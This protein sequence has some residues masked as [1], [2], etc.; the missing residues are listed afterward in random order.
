MTRASRLVLVAPLLLA[1]LFVAPRASAGT[2][3][4]LSSLAALPS[5]VAL[6][7]PE[8]PQAVPG[9]TVKTREPNHSST[10]WYEVNAATGRGYC[11]S[12]RE[13]ALTWMPS[14]GSSDRGSAEELDL[15]RVLEKD[16]KGTLERTRVRFDPPTGSLTA[17][18]RSHVELREI[19]RTAAGIVVWAYR[20]GRHVVVLARNIERGIESRNLSNADEGFSAFISADGCPYAGVRLDG[21]KP[22][23]GTFAQ[24]S[25]VLPAQGKGKD[26]VVPKFVINAS[27]SRVAR[28]PEPILAVRVSVH[29]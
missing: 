11:L 4:P 29:D 5:P 19:T 14:W 10:T 22:E 27:L 8:S 24:L 26:K 23:A 3:A 13:G 12:T 18:G 7:V 17:V 25:G 9:V 20:D 15:V 1:A 6:R 21:R 28:D 2:T 16:G